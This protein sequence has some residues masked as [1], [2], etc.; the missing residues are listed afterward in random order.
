MN[1]PCPF[2][3]FKPADF[4]REDRPGLETASDLFTTANL[5]KVSSASA[6]IWSR[7]HDVLRGSGEELEETFIQGFEYLQ[8]LPCDL[9]HHC[10]VYMNLGYLSGQTIEHDHAHAVGSP[11]PLGYERRLARSGPGEYFSAMISIHRQI[12]LTFED[13]S[14]LVGFVNL[15]PVKEHDLTIISAEVRPGVRLLRRTLQALK[16]QGLKSFSVAMIPAPRDPARFPGWP[17]F[18]WRILCRDHILGPMELFGSSVIGLDPFV[19]A[20]ELSA[21]IAA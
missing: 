14:G 10:R 1:T 5:A 16:A 6:L 18:V 7:S 2:C 11:R 8:T 20:R 19:E 17:A 13:S 4:C 3:D 15:C 21:A 9:A 12:G